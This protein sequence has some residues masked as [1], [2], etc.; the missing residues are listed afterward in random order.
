MMQGNR[1]RENHLSL[2]ACLQGPDVD[3]RTETAS[4]RL[5]SS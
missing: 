1:A 5:Q 4:S 3:C 2:I